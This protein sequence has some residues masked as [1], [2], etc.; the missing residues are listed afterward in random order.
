MTVNRAFSKLTIV[1]LASA[2]AT[3]TKEI[4]TSLKCLQAVQSWLVFS[5]TNTRPQRCLL[6]MNAGNCF[7]AQRAW[8]FDPRTGQCREFIFTG[9]GGNENRFRTSGECRQ[10]CN[11]KYI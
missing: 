11:G 10:T 8:Y 9:C 7:N 6:P 1:L 5:G 2:T 3:T 4:S